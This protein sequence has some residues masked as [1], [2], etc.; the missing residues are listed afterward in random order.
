[1]I[2]VLSVFTSR[3]TLYN[4]IRLSFSKYRNYRQYKGYACKY[5]Y[6]I[7]SFKY[8]ILNNVN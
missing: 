1:M 2:S 8:A 6:F 4:A 5:S 3:F 7:F